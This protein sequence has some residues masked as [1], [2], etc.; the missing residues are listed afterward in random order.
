MTP[1]YG[2]KEQS[3]RSRPNNDSLHRRAFSA[4]R[5]VPLRLKWDFALM[6]AIDTPR[7]AES[8]RLA[9]LPPLKIFD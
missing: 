9:I 5:E 6:D 1:V 4:F 7:V 3:G 8:V 2:V